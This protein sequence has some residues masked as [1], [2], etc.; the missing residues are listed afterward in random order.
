[1]AER[2]YIAR[3]TS[4]GLVVELDRQ[5]ITIVKLA[6]QPP[7]KPDP[8]AAPPSAATEAGE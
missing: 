1:M 4:Q 8:P 5:T 7:E 3:L 6:E 2:T